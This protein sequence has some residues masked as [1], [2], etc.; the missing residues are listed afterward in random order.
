MTGDADRQ[1]FLSVCLTRLTPAFCSVTVA[2][3]TVYFVTKFLFGDCSIWVVRMVWKSSPILSLLANLLL[4][5]P[6]IP[7]TKAE[8]PGM[9]TEVQTWNLSSSR[10]SAWS[11]CSQDFPL[12]SSKSLNTVRMT[13][14]FIPRISKLWCSNYH[15]KV[16]TVPP[17]TSVCHVHRLQSNCCTFL[18][19]EG[20]QALAT[21]PTVINDCLSL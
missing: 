9:P 16:S 17:I 11:R 10:F 1:T 6:G 7:A 15:A 20:V 5:S 2:Y 18:E 13:S 12:W 14:S 19:M 3:M 21:C 8:A 4:G